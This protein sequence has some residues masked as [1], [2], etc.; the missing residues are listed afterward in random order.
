MCVFC[1]MSNLN[2]NMVC[3]FSVPDE[4][5]CH[6]LCCRTTQCRVLTITGSL[7]SGNLPAPTT[8]VKKKKSFY[9][10][11]QVRLLTGGGHTWV[12]ENQNRGGKVAEDGTQSKRE[13]SS[14]FCLPKVYPVVYT[15]RRAAA[16][17]A[18]GATLW[19]KMKYVTYLAVFQRGF[20]VRGSHMCP[21]F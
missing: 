15:P 20:S 17:R 14:S 10:L 19:S 9:Y 16:P 1:K 18:E 8:Q 21:V 5:V 3:L 4:P 6:T 11:T 7:F 12:M 13:S 2:L